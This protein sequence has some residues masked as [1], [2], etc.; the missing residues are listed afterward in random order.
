MATQ[1]TPAAAGHANYA[2]QDDQMSL[3]AERAATDGSSVPDTLEVRS[4]A[5]G[6]MQASVG[7]VRRP[8]KVALGAVAIVVGTLVAV[9][10]MRRRPGGVAVS[11][12]RG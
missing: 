7:R 3:S 10:L 5:L 12:T 6:V 8:A 4:D 1:S 11:A 9:G 2:T